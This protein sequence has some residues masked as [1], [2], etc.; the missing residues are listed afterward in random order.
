MHKIKT[1]ILISSL[2]IL[3]SCAELTQ[4]AQTAVN[5]NLP[6]TNAEIIGGLK[7]ALL[8]GTDSSVTRLSAADGYLKDQA[9]KILLPPEAKTIVDNLSKLPGGEKLV[10]DVILRIN[11]A[12]EDAA[13]GAKP[14][15]VNSIREMTFADGLQILKGPDNAAT[16]YFRMK[17]NEQLS[18]LYRPKIRESLNKNLIAGISTQQSWNELTNNW[19]KIAGT[20]VGQ[21]AGLKTVDVKLEDYLLQQALNGMYLKIEEREKDIRT[22]ASARVTVL[23]KRVFGSQNT[24]N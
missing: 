17:T 20:I 6:L 22:N 10:D 4:I 1:I 15:F 5:Q 12:A 19:N 7:D 16:Q 8:V 9:V 21:M 11:R 2:F 24:V 18:E 14:I 23:L 13:K 3:N